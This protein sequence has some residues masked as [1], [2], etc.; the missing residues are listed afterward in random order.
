MEN[1]KSRMKHMFHIA[2]V[3]QATV[4]GEKSV[5]YDIFSLKTEREDKIIIIIAN[6]KQFYRVEHGLISI[7][8]D[9]IK[10]CL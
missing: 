8:I 2:N 9:W 10:I 1:S 5:R 3:I 7:N 6:I 4:V